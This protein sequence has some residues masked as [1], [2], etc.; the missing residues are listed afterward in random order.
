VALIQKRAGNFLEDFRVGQLL[1]H[2]GGRTVTAGIHAHF[3]DFCYTSNPLHKNERYAEL[4][5]YRSMILPPGIA[6]IVAFS[7]TVED[8]S[9]N[10]RAN[11]E[12]IDM[13]FGTPVYIGD[14]GSRSDGGAQPGW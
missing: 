8:I 14:T 7:Q 1:R 11:L 5:G 10:A 12:Y 4:H 3:T 6:M 2:K 13:R 9:E